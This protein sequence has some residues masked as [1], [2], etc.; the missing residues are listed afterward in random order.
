MPL[1]L[2][3]FVGSGEMLGWAKDNGCPW[4]KRTCALIAAGGHLDVLQWAREDDHMCAWNSMTCAR[5][6][7]GGHLEAGAYS[8]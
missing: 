6:A 2:E 4:R 1:E 7:G 5:A 8:T 3:A